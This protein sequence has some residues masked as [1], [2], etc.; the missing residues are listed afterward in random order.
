MTMTSFASTSLAAMAPSGDTFERVN[1]GTSRVVAAL[2]G[3]NASGGM[4]A[5][6]CFEML[7]GK[8][9]LGEVFPDCVAEPQADPEPPPPLPEPAG[10]GPAKGCVAGELAWE[11]TGVSE[12]GCRLNDGED[13]I[14][15]G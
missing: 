9:R 10:N 2:R 4:D 11:V 7:V 1:P 15:E 3:G 14:R 6:S 8:F 5:E 12:R 13:D